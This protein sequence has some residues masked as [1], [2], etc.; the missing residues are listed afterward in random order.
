MPD[1]GLGGDLAQRD[2]VVEVRPQDQPAAMRL[3]APR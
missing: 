2:T 1:P 3:C